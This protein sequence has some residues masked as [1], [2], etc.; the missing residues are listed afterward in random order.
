M[1]AN[2]TD[3]EF[4]KIINKGSSKYSDNIEEGFPYWCLEVAFPFLSEDEIEN[5]IFGLSGNDD[6]IDAFFVNESSKDI[7]F[8]QCKSSRSEKQMGAC[9]KEWFTY[10]YTVPNRLKNDDY[11]DKHKNERIAEIS[12]EF[13]IY[14]K[15]GY[16]TNFYFFHL[17]YNPN[18]EIINSYNTNGENFQYYGFEELKDVYFEYASRINLS[19]P[20]SFDINIDYSSKPETINQKIGQHYTLISI[21]TGDEIVRLRETYKYQLF[22]KNVR[23]NLGLNKVNKQIVESADKNKSDF[24]FYNN[25]LTITAAKFKTKGKSVKVDRPQ[26]INGAQTVDSIFTAYSKRLNKLKREL[27]CRES[28]KR[29][30]S[31]EFREIK[32]MFRIIQTN[33]TEQDFETNVIKSNN[34]QNAVQIRDFYSNN[35]EQVELQRKFAKQGYF[36]EIKR[37][38]RNYIKK[39]F[40]TKLNLKL[41]DFIYKDEL[42]D[43]ERI[44]SIMRAFKLEPGAREVGA[45]RI[46]N[47]D[48]V[49]NS[50]FGGSAIDVTDLV[51][52]EM[53]FAYNIF[54]IIEHESKQYNAIL[55][56]LLHLDDR[57]SDFLKIKRLIESSL[58]LNDVIKG[59][60]KDL[61]AYNKNKEKHKKAV[62]RYI[63]FSQGKYLALAIFKLVIEECGYYNSLID[64]E[65]YKDKTF[66]KDRIVAPW[67][68]MILSKLL[69]KEYERAVF[70]DGISLNSFYL[71]PKTFEN[72]YENFEQ[73]DITED[74]EYTEIFKLRLS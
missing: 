55:K 72:I 61:T 42:L 38:E 47:D 49:Y 20:E 40:H 45:K 46:L 2:I 12:S 5:S 8:I 44:A 41:N 50:I 13:A 66:I 26:I 57:N 54:N 27:A 60:Y 37:G 1:T 74:K 7:Y 56:L 14:S 70:S 17:G 10:L 62:R 30:V 35:P 69:V 51:V 33:E 43:I 52:K 53:I 36:Y 21:I 68:P 3:K 19:E 11:I 73:L 22:D 32:V 65:L 59:K 31:E 6:S 15:K 39:N 9:D 48:D 4:F 71:R 29:K 64:T 28:A 23:Y 16:T 63:P 34:T 67:L 24:Y 58:V 18:E 25:G